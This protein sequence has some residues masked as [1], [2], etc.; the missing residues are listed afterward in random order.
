MSD[1]KK[2]DINE[3]ISWGLTILLILVVLYAKFGTTIYCQCP[4]VKVINTCFNST[5]NEIVQILKNYTIVQT[6]GNNTIEVIK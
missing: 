6:M 1:Q 3:Y 5:D 4:Q 2:N